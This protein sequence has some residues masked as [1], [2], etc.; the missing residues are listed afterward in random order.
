MQEQRSHDHRSPGGDQAVA[1]DVVCR[2]SRPA[3][4]KHRAGRRNLKI[5]PGYTG[6]RPG[7][8]GPAALDSPVPVSSLVA[9]SMIARV[10]SESPSIPSG[11]TQ[12]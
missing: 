2:F 4:C 11:M 3:R 10:K 5:A 1:A 9:T 12:T 8:Y 7:P 6:T